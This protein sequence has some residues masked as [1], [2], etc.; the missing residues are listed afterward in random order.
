MIPEFRKKGKREEGRE[1][2]G[3]GGKKGGK[4]SKLYVFIQVKF[5]VYLLSCPCF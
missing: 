1:G 5:K 3:E 2:R 4:K